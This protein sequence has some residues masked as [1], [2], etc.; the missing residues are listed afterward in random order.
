[1]KKTL[2]EIS[3]IV[4]LSCIV[5]LPLLSGKVI[6]PANIYKVTPLYKNVKG[7]KSNGKTITDGDVLYNTFPWAL[8]IENALR[9]GYNPLWQFQNLAGMPLLGN[10]Q[11]HPYYPLEFP[12]FFLFS[13]VLVINISVFLEIILMAVGGYFLISLYSKN[14]TS[15]ILGSLLIAFN[16]FMIGWL[17][18]P[19]ATIMS[20]F[21]FVLFTI[22]KTIREEFS[23]KTLVLISSI[24]TAFIGLS[25]NIEMTL[26]LLL[27]SVLYLIS[28]MIREKKFYI[29][30]FKFL[31]LGIILGT[32]ISGIQWYPAVIDLLRSFYFHIRTIHSTYDAISS[33][34]LI[35]FLYPGIFGVP[36]SNALTLINYNFTET[37][38]FIA[39]PAFYLGIL[40]F[41]NKEKRKITI[42]ISSLLIIII[43]IAVNIP[44]ISYLV[45][46]PLLKD[47][48]H[49]R[50]IAVIPIFYA[51][52]VAIGIESL[53]NALGNNFKKIKKYTLIFAII[54]ILISSLLILRLF[55][56]H[57]PSFNIISQSLKSI[58]KEDILF[59]ILA[60]VILL[61]I[62]IKKF[63]IQTKKIVLSTAIIIISMF[64]L[65]YI[66]FSYWQF[67]P[68]SNTGIFKPENKYIAL[69]KNKNY[70][71]ST[72]NI[73]P[74]DVNVL[75]NFNEFQGYDPVIP[76]TYTKYFKAIGHKLQNIYFVSSDVNKNSV[77]L[78]RLAAIN[79]ILLH[80][81]QSPPL[82]FTKVS[83]TRN[84]KFDK[85]VT[86][87]EKENNLGHKFTK[88]LYYLAY[89]YKSSDIK[90]SNKTFVSDLKK[91]MGNGKKGSTLK[92]YFKYYKV[93]T[94]KENSS[95]HKLLS[96]KIPSFIVYKIKNPI[97]IVSIPKNLKGNM[98][99]ENN[100]ITMIENTKH[101]SFAV[102]SAKNISNNAKAK[103]SD[104][105][106]KGNSI[107][108]N[109][110]DPT[111]K[112]AFVSISEIYYPGWKAYDNNKQIPI[113]RTNGIFDGIKVNEINNKIQL[114][115][116]PDNFIIGEYM[117]FIGL[118]ILLLI[119]FLYIPYFNKILIKKRDN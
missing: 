114:K 26:I 101:Q 16:G 80:P 98:Q 14:S 9:S 103:I 96:T 102:T 5:F 69:F 84:S 78:L 104:Y 46:L 82:N 55:T 13:P 88:P 39:L 66:F 90:Y 6:F 59:A 73:A 29:K 30:S 85:L 91:Y 23:R 87:F 43:G 34:Y 44:L 97:P 28:L 18:W 107:N 99:G 105:N 32:L 33:I 20:I 42:W 37:S 19:L 3:T 108:F 95:L 86:T 79:Y 24:V 75:S 119:I 93:L 17:L 10:D 110:S 100:Q 2:I 53:F 54:I 45:D 117:T 116:Q 83:N 62:Y 115:Y 74:P 63:K 50:I 57:V 56:I 47:T 71:M 70:R 38:F 48:L 61:V 49:H 41:V 77:E 8:E 60:I 21:P 52:L 31:F 92:K 64:P 113:F 11:S 81:Y 4:F 7:V 94:N 65:V 35:K 15:R 106:I 109:V 27:V 22:E 58:I 1:M 72:F 25:G 76:N 67:V 118:G 36:W 111:R 68:L 112:S 12:L 40:A 51:I 89:I